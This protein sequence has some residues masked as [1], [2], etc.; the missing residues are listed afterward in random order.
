MQINNGEKKN[1]QYVSFYIAAGSKLFMNEVSPIA[2]GVT[3]LRASADVIYSDPNDF[4]V[5]IDYSERYGLILL[6]SAMGILSAFENG[7]ATLVV[8]SKISTSLIF[9]SVSE[10]IED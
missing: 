4:S 1:T 8:M 2:A 5:A 9:T 10:H 6:I 7:T 3:A